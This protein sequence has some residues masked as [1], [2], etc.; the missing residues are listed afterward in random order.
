MSNDTQ[1]T[2]QDQVT[3]ALIN[4]AAGMVDVIDL[5]AERRSSERFDY[6]HNVEV[7]LRSINGTTAKPIVA[8]GVNISSGGLCIESRVVFRPGAV[9]IARLKRSDG[10]FAVIGVQVCRCRY[11]SNMMHRT[12]MRFIPLPKDVNTNPSG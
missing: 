6:P 9:G 5:E 12:G 8:Q 1:D 10:S 11:V 3:D 4:D 7:I 2:Q